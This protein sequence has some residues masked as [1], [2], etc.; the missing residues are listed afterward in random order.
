MDYK[1]HPN[2]RMRTAEEIA[3][4]IQQIDEEILGDISNFMEAKLVYDGGKNRSK[5]SCEYITMKQ[6]KEIMRD[7]HI[8]KSILLWILGV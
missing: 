4:R 1:T 5:D 6:S 2:K 8:E 7:K 3:E